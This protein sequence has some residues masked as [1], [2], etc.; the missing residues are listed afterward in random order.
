MI[1]ILKLGQ[2]TI[3]TGPFSISMLKLQ[4]VNPITWAKDCH[5]PPRTGNGSTISPIDDLMVTTGTWFYIVLP[6]LIRVL[7]EI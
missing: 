1:A 3:S 2:L 4:K 7:W 5:E 6:S